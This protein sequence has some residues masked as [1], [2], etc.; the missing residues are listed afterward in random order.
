MQTQTTATTERGT[1]IMLDVPSA[2]GPTL[3]AT[4]RTTRH[5]CPARPTQPNRADHRSRRTRKTMMTRPSIS[6]I[7]PSN[8]SLH[9]RRPPRPLRSLPRPPPAPVLLAHPLKRRSSSTTERWARVTPKTPRLTLLAK[10]TPSISDST[11][12]IAQG[13]HLR[14]PHRSAR[15]VQERPPVT[16]A[17]PRTTRTPSRLPPLS[18]RPPTVRGRPIE[19]SHTVAG[20][21]STTLTRATQASRLSSSLAPIRAMRRLARASRLTK[22]QMHGRSERA[23][24]GRAKAQP[25]ISPQGP[26]SDV[27]K[28]RFVAVTTRNGDLDLLAATSDGPLLPFPFSN[29]VRST[30]G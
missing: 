14:P 27:F 11:P 7:S 28:S 6:T 20:P 5:T 10:S 13:Q 18:R 23:R 17:R 25:G 29:M 21:E 22:G 4:R 16:A 3:V 8:Q 2:Q 30:F 12:P 1:E 19:T 15:P 26:L 24:F 9:R